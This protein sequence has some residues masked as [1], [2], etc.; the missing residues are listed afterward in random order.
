MLCIVMPK[1]KGPS[2]HAGENKWKVQE[3]SGWKW[4]SKPD[5]NGVFHWKILKPKRDIF[6]DMAQCERHPKKIKY[7]YEEF[8][9][10]WKAMTKELRRHSV[11]THVAKWASVGSFI[12]DAWDD[13]ME[14]S[15]ATAVKDGRIAQSKR[16]EEEFSKKC[17]MLMFT[18][19]RLY[20]A[21]VKSGVMNIQW[22]LDNKGALEAAHKVLKETFGKNVTLS[23]NANKTINVRLNKLG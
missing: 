22:S 5:K 13:A 15:V 1:R 21:A 10:K 6:E 2:R 12:D 23:K 4:I 19:F 7:D 3:A 17:G 14:Y 16:K 9:R 8:L 11:Y 20:W 18:E